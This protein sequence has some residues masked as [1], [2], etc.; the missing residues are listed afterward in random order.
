MTWAEDVDKVR[1]VIKVAK[2]ST[3]IKHVGPILS[4]NEAPDKVAEF[5]ALNNEV[6]EGWKW[7]G[8]WSSECGNLYAQFE[9]T[10]TLELQ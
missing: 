7:T 8:H 9:I 2:T 10:Q 5:M 6:M 3:V 4:L 1:S